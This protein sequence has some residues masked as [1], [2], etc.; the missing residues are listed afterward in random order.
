MTSS[1]TPLWAETLRRRAVREISRVGAQQLQLDVLCG[2][3]VRKTSWRWR[4]PRRSA[5]SSIRLR[6]AGGTRHAA[7]TCCVRHRDG[8]WWQREGRRPAR[9]CLRSAL[10]RWRQG[11]RRSDGRL[12][13]SRRL[14][15]GVDRR[16]RGGSR[17]RYPGPIQRSFCR[18]QCIPIGPILKRFD[19]NFGCRR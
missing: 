16:L 2:C 7:K 14:R 4:C 18:R 6:C 9:S 15:G 1:P 12:R 10:R 3:S 5:A 11:R 8:W 17:R 13:P 19:V